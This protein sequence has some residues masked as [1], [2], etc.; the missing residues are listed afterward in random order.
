MV[1]ERS[2]TIESDTFQDAL[3]DMISLYFIMERYNLSVQLVCSVVKH[4]EV[5]AWYQRQADDST[6]GN[7]PAIIT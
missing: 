1:V 7:M 5:C 2:I 3:T 4:L 6:I